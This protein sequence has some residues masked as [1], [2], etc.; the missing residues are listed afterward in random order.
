MDDHI[1]HRP[2][3]KK[4]ENENTRENKDRN[5]A[6]IQPIVQKIGAK[7]ADVKHRAMDQNGGHQ[8]KALDPIDAVHAAR[9]KGK[10]AD[11]ENSDHH[12]IHRKAFKPRMAAKDE[13]EDRK[14]DRAD[15]EGNE[16]ATQKFQS[17]FSHN[18]SYLLLI[19]EKHRLETY[20]R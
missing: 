6:E 20:S 2:D 5:H 15:A 7:I 1:D 14:N 12:R 10:R 16:A 4:A 3:G 13:I 19:S 18:Y 11:G 8:G 17:I 9:D